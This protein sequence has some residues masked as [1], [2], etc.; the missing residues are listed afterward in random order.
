MKNQS[1]IKKEIEQKEMKIQPI[2]IRDAA[3]AVP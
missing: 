1:R 3:K 2:E